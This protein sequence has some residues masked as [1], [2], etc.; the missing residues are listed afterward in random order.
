M[1]ERGFEDLKLGRWDLGGG[2]ESHAP[3]KILMSFLFLGF[4]FFRF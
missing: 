4:S 3:E 2:L 1:E